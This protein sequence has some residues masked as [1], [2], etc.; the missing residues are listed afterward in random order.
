MKMSADQFRKIMLILALAFAIMGFTTGHPFMGGA[1]LLFALAM[2]N[3]FGGKDYNS[4]NTYDKEVKNKNDL[5]VDEIYDVIKNTNTAFGKCWI[6]Q[7]EKFKGK[8]IIFGP[9]VFKSYV[10]ISVNNE[11]IHL[12]TGNDIS[13]II[14]DENDRYRFD[15]V[16]DLSDVE[17]TPKKFSVFSAAM[18]GAV[19]LLE[20]L[21]DSV[22]KMANG[23]I[24]TMP[25]EIGI[26][27]LF[28]YNS[29]DSIVRDIKDG[30]YAKCSSINKP[31]SV[32]IYYM[33][34]HELASVKAIGKNEK[35]GFAIKMS[36]E[37]YGTIFHM[38]N[39][40]HDEFICET[41]E[42]E[43][44]AVSL[45]AV[46]RGNLGTNYRIKLAGETKAIVGGT[47]AIK[48]EKEGVVEN[49]I[50]CSY[51]DDYLV[52]YLLIQ[53]FIMTFNHWVK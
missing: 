29:S 8:C 24:V 20:E 3:V 40:G 37:N 14:A 30:E 10:L 9:D 5:T 38:E 28:Y 34:N 39:S 32:V 31:L 49:D 43:L 41:G 15:V 22:Q 36:G 47:A 7:H 19:N 33:D 53:E 18:L 35:N 17:V 25:E 50:I 46:M 42:G 6:A 51:D 16:A 48:F 12:Y 45:R 21:T 1:A 44:K 4:R 2:W 11:T 23:N 26:F 13:S 52:L 27:N